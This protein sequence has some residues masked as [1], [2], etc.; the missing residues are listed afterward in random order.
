[1]AVLVKVSGAW[2]AASPHV[3]VSGAWVRPLHVHV[4]QGGTWKPLWAYSWQ[5]GDWGSCSAS[6][7]GG[8]QTRTATCRR[9]DGVD[10]PDAYCAGLTKPPTSTDCNTQPC[11]TYGWQAGAWSDCSNACGSGTQTRSTGCYRSDGAQVSASYCSGGAPASTQSCTATC[12]YRY[13]SWPSPTV[14]CGV[15]TISRSVTCWSNASGKWVQQGSPAVC[16]A[17]HGSPVEPNKQVTTCTGCAYN[18]AATVTAK[19]KKMNGMAEQGRTDWTYAEVRQLLIQA[20]GSVQA[21][22]NAYGSSEKVCPW[23]AGSKQC[24]LNAGYT[25]YAGT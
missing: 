8:T 6:C 23:P 19:V 13:G 7:G 2:R 5:T 21:W 1:M 12:E 3:K 10:L 11:Y 4:K 14:T 17:A 24:C 25:W 22:W 20:S 9:S 18:E 15:E 16:N